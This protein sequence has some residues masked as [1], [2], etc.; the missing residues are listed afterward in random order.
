MI[1][2]AVWVFVVD[3]GD[4][5]GAPLV[6]WLCNKVFPSSEILHRVKDL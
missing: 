1:I 6:G 4:G 3:G 2:W 5:G